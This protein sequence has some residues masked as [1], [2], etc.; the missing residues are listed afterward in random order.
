[1][2]LIHDRKIPFSIQPPTTLD[3]LVEKKDTHQGVVFQMKEF[4]YTTLEALSTT[5]EEAG[6]GLIVLLDQLQDPQNL[7]GII[8]T[9]VA[10]GA[11][12][13]VILKD[14]AAQITSS[15]V[16]ASAGMAFSIPICLEVNLSRAIDLLKDK[17]FWV[18]GAEAGGKPYPL[19][20]LSSKMALVM[21]NEGYGLR[22][23][24]QEQCDYLISIPM[25]RSVDSLN[26]SV[27]SG[28]L[29]YAWWER[30][31]KS[32]QEHRK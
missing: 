4:P 3:R 26:V 7:G 24:V 18:Y 14:N 9:S 31:W 22:K 13:V 20:E 27:S 8:R 19:L 28:I 6:S 12:A 1:M 21:G 25:A 32:R 5:L 29:S 10:V 23:R 17:G 11:L 2:A 15:V 30:Q 16:K